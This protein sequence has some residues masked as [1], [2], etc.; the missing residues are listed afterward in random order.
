MKRL[1][2]DDELAIGWT[3]EPSDQTLLANKAGATR[4]GF[5]ALLTFFRH[6]GRFPASKHEVPAAVVTHLASQVGVPAEAYVAYDWR[7]R[8]IKYHRVQIRTALGFRETSVEDADQLVDWL[9]DEVV[10][11]ER[12]QDRVRAAVY[13]RCRELRLE[14]PTPERVERLVRSAVA[15]HEQQVSRTVRGRLSPMSVEA[16]DGLLTPSKSAVTEGESARATLVEL[17]ADPA[18]PGWRVCSPKSPNCSG[19]ARSGYRQ[20]CSRMSRPRRAR[21]TTSEC[22]LKNPT[23]CVGIPSPC[24]RRSL[25]PGQA[26]APVS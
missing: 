15:S 8:T 5:V 3:L 4:L 16:W 19:F 14:P 11:H 6:E 22:R 12:A 21:D 24:D 17:K 9:A 7:G 23:N 1:W 2:D 26:F 10:P 18:R 13:T 20:T 25:R